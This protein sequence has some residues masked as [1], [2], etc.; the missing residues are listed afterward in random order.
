MP[1]YAHL[2]HVTV[3]FTCRVFVLL[4]ALRPQWCSKEIPD[5]ANSTWAKKYPIVEVRYK[6]L[7]VSRWG[8]GDQY[9]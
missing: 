1:P 4:L 7:V 2:T 6:A 9:I 8:S 3:F 5:P